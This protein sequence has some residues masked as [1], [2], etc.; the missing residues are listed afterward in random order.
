MATITL[1]IPA[2]ITTRVLDAIAAQY[3][4]QV[5][6]N[7]QPNPQTKAQFVKAWLISTLVKAVKEHEVASATEK[8]QNAAGIDADTNIIIT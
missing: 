5:T 4:Y 8:A 3:S 6:I 2:T 1:T 7:G